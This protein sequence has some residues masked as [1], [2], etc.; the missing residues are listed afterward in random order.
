MA[1]PTFIPV[2]R[3]VFN[4]NEKKYL[5][6]CITSGWV[7]SRGSF[8]DAF[9]AQFAEVTG[10]RYAMSTMNGTTALHLALLALGIGPGDEVI[11]PALTFAASAAVIAHV[12]ATP[13]F[14]DVRPDNFNI[15]ETL[16]A[17]KI[18][19][20]TKAIMVV[21][22]YGYPVAM[23]AI[24]TL[25]KEHHL[26]IIEDAAEAQATRYRGSVVGT[27]GDIGCYSF[28]GNKIITTGEGGMCVTND[29]A[30]LEKMVLYKNHGM[31]PER[32][33]WHTVIGFNFRM[34]NIQAAV[35]LAQM[36]QLPEFITKR[37]WLAAR[38]H[39][40]LAD[41]PAIT[42]PLVGNDHEAPVYWMYTV[43]VPDGETRNRLATFLAEAGIETRPAFPPLIAMPVYAA[44]VP[45]GE[46][47]PVALNMGERGL[48]LPSS[49]DLTEKDVVYITDTIKRFFS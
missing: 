21:H 49:T 24:L 8:I 33:Y 15:N 23:D 25:A 4:G 48:N 18:T 38:Y 5:E 32:R 45:G 22:L 17:G 7:S 31:T 43:L 19:P 34:T 27:L 9:E 6:E 40:L 2:A 14:V 13:V 29:K 44:F 11:V 46:T 1:A 35:G 28:F 36:E 41:C 30:L 10:A 3:P 16:I 20:R 47:F 42:R 39:E 37:Q 12:G 26:R